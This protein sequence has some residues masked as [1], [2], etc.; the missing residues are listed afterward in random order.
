MSLTIH[1]DLEQRSE[2]WHTARRGIVTA[3]VVG[4]L[5]TPTLKVANNDTSRAL[6]ATLA[7]E[8]ITG[9][10]EEAFVNN[11]MWRGV[12]DEPRA[13]AY[14]SEHFAPVAEAGFMVRDDW[15]FRIGFS[16]DGL[17]R[18]DGLWET[19]SRK[20]KK[21]LQTIVADQVP[22]ENVA[23]LQAGLLVSGRD[24]ID[25]MSWCGGMKPYVK[26]VY[27]DPKWQAVI[28]AAVEAFEK[29]VEAMTATYY[30][31]VGSLPDTERVIELEVTF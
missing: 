4:Q 9:W 28:V 19:K 23:Q 3:S 27:P 22:A 2:D 1:E 18:E 30:N 17:I 29:A 20:P 13:R 31:R 7:A 8:R 12:E 6:T 24:W 21:H 15:G 10:T 25:Y 26:R 16:P 5:V 11:D 14:Y